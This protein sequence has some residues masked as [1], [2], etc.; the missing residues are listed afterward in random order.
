M[1]LVGVVHSWDALVEKVKGGEVDVVLWETSRARAPARVDELL[2]SAPRL[3]V[4]S[5]VAAGPEVI[6]HELR[7][8]ATPL[9]N[10]KINGLLQAIR[11]RSSAEHV[12][13]SP[14]SQSG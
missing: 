8:Y 1:R 3:R 4:F 13:S 7:P 5:I 6:L 2:F 10:V 14:G 12:V 11:G 9:G